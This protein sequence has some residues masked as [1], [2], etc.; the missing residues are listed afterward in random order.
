M[1]TVSVAV[2]PLFTKAVRKLRRRVTEL[3]QFQRHQELQEGVAIKQFKCH[4]FSCV[5]SSSLHTI[6]VNLSMWI[7][8]MLDISERAMH[9][10]F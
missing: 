9:K 2:A 10:G 4:S 5:S 8:I 1:F 3:N 7:D 6:N